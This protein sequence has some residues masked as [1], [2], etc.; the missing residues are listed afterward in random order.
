VKELYDRSQADRTAIGAACVARREKQKCGAQ[1]L[2][3][4]AE[5]VGGDLRNWRKSSF[6][7]PREF[8]LDQREIVADQIKNP[9]DRQQRDGESPKLFIGLET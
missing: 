4:P 1:A 8:F 9:F 2:S 5:Q 3:A 7:L 6:A